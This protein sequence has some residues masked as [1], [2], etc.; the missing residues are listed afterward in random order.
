[1]LATAVDLGPQRTT[2]EIGMTAAA[3]VFRFSGREYTLTI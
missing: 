1:V 2:V 3:V